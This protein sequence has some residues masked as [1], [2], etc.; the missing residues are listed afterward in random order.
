[1]LQ[2]DWKSKD[3]TTV[4]LAGVMLHRKVPIQW[5]PIETALHFFNLKLF[6]YIQ[7]ELN[8]NL[9]RINSYCITQNMIKNA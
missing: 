1:M 4:V 3:T 7:T 2:L 5:S 8:I 6:R 9:L